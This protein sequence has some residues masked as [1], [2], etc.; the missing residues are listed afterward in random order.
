MR[1]DVAVVGAFQ[2]ND[3][4]T[5]SGS[6]W[7]YKRLGDT[8]HVDRKLVAADGIDYDYFGYAVATDGRKVVV[9]GFGRDSSGI[10]TGMVYVFKKSGG[11]WLQ[12][13]QFIPSTLLRT[14]VIRCSSR[15]TAI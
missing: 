2:D 15:S 13:Q 14:R 12:E 11:V 7:V 3:R 10:H 6:A 8:W 9:G 4:G 1:G 5:F